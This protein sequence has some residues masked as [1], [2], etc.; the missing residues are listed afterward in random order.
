[1]NFFVIDLI[2]SH[3]AS[4]LPSRRSVLVGVSS[5]IAAATSGCLGG[6]SHYQLRLRNDSSDPVT[7]AIHLTTQ[8]ATT[9]VETT[10]DLGPEE[11]MSLV[12]SKR[13]LETE[14]DIDGK[15]G[16]SGFNWTSIPSCLI[17]GLPTQTITIDDDTIGVEYRCKPHNE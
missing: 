15:S 12:V 10:V 2:H 16:Q 7:G 3:M 14:L 1:M 6:D 4:N 11:S 17:G 5:V 8:N 9:P 13:P